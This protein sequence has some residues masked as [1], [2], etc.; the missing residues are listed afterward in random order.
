MVITVL[1]Q[2]MLDILNAFVNQPQ[3]RVMKS[4]PQIGDEAG[5]DFKCEKGCILRQL[6]QQLPGYGACACPELDGDKGAR[7]RQRLDHRRGK[8]V[9]ARQNRSYSVEVRKRF[10][11]K[12]LKAHRLAHNPD[13][14]GILPRFVSL[15]AA[16]TR[17]FQSTTCLTYDAGGKKSLHRVL[18]NNK[19]QLKKEHK[20]QCDKPLPL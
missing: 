15:T 12:G 16:A 14:Y 6:I 17:E 4:F 19:S 9:R 3:A 2:H 18:P 11:S 8:V 10:R 1:P 13:P 7:E 5:I 20:F